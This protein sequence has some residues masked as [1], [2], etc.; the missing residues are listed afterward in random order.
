MKKRVWLRQLRMSRGLTQEAVATQ[1][2]IDRGFYA[3]IENGMRDPSM[4]VAMNISDTLGVHPQIFFVEMFGFPKANTRASYAVFS[5][6]D[7][8]LKYTWI[9]H[10]CRNAEHF[11]GKRDDEYEVNEGILELIYLNLASTVTTPL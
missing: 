2:F 11:I 6:C 8:E 3:Q 5:H 7:L 9:F 10:P 4:H 1:S